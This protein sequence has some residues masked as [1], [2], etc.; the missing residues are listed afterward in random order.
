MMIALFALTVAAALSSDITPWGRV[1]PI[2]SEGILARG[3]H[4]VIEMKW[5]PWFRYDL[6]YRVFCDSACE[7]LIGYMD[8]M[9]DMR[10]LREFPDCTYT[11]IGNVTHYDSYSDP[12]TTDTMGITPIDHYENMSPALADDLYYRKVIGIRALKK[13]KNTSYSI[14]VTHRTID[15]RAIIVIAVIAFIILCGIASVVIFSGIFCYCRLLANYRDLSKNESCS[16]NIC[17]MLSENLRLRK[18][19]RQEQKAER[20]RKDERYYQK[21][22]DRVKKEIDDEEKWKADAIERNRRDV[23]GTSGLVNTHV[24]HPQV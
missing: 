5:F 11:T 16:I 14:Q 2:E 8:C 4:P 1:V 10:F 20:E 6:R 17:Y 15:Y 12:A 3:V 23:F 21:R 7:V 9:D 24:R 19:R 18:E 22:R 13:K